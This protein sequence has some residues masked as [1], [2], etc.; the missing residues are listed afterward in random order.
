M[1]PPSPL[2]GVGH[3]A[4]VMV[5][6][7]VLTRDTE[8]FESVVWA[9]TCHDLRRVDDNDDPPHGFRAGTWVRQQL[10]GKLRQPLP[11]LELIASACDWHV[12]PDRDA[13]WDHPVLWL[14]KDADGLDRVRLYDLDPRYLRHPKTR[15]W[16]TAA[17]RLFQ[18][19][20][21]LDN[22]H[23][24]WHEASR[25]HIPVAELMSYVNQ[26]VAARLGREKAGPQVSVRPARGW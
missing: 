12:C 7:A 14:L 20:Q 16:I 6:A 18:A 8:W 3:T 4:R 19:T 17:T 15:Q 22:P 13:E 5:W 2:H 24:I 11:N 10:P 21:E 25:L 9:A 1:Q 23:E 26:Q